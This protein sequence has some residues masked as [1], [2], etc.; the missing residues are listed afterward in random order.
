MR[1]GLYSHQESARP[2]D[3]VSNLDTV[4]P[5]SD[6][7]YTQGGVTPSRGYPPSGPNSLASDTS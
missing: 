3:L 6:G 2:Q 7:T 5:R 4:P 1:D